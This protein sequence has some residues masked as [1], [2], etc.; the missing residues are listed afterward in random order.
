MIKD[1]SIRVD[2]GKMTQ[3]SKPA[4]GVDEWASSSVNYQDGCEHDCRYCYAKAMA[5]RFHRA[6]PKSW[7]HP[8]V[9]TKDVKKSY[10]RRE[11]RIM[12]PTSHDITPSNL[13]ETLLVLR[14]LLQSG[15]E[16]LIV[17]KPHLDCVKALCADLTGYK[18]QILFRFTIGS[19]D[20][21]VLKYWEPGAPTFAE[22]LAA[23]KWAY[24]KR[25][26]T[27]VSCEPMLD[28]RVG[29]V[30]RATKPYV[31]DAIWLGRVNRLRQTLTIN[32]PGD[33]EAMEK[34]DQLLAEQTDDY[35]RE[36][37]RQYKADPQ[38]KFKDSIKQAVG[39]VRP[40]KVGLD[41]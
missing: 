34:A 27:S 25:F 23:L 28:K 36:L 12:L 2:A 41:V 1:E 15:N 6:T 33:T 32:C 30:V 19:A 17:S 4:H 26:A 18:T 7:C 16:L 9:R 8:A 11:G 24:Q 29:E 10:R 35:L 5:I 14:K 3:E 37:Y 21:K 13:A 20:D 22:R 40:T 39:L 38:I 31:T